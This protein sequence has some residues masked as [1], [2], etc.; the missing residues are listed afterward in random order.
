MVQDEV[1]RYLNCKD[2]LAPLLNPIWLEI[3]Y[4]CLEKKGMHVKKKSVPGI[5]YGGFFPELYLGCLPTTTK[6]VP[7]TGTFFVQQIFRKKFQCYTFNWRMKTRSNFAWEKKWHAHFYT[8][9]KCKSYFICE[10][11]LICL[12]S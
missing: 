12:H 1:G 9:K 6:Y 8:A 3:R 7:N 10:S 2:A 5:C 11:N 4:A